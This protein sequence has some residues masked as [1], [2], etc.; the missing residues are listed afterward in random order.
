MNGGVN[1]CHLAAY[2]RFVTEA[3]RVYQSDQIKAIR[4]HARPDQFITHNFHGDMSDGDPHA[5]SKDLDVA[6]SII[7]SVAGTST[8]R[9]KRPGSTGCVASND[10]TSG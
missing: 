3:T 8:R 2:R 1:P 10:R 4:A 6:R 7:T 5:L 9:T